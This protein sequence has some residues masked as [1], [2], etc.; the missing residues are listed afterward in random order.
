MSNI[1]LTQDDWNTLNQLAYKQPASSADT[2]AAWALLG[3]KGDS[4]GYVASQVKPRG[5]VLLFAFLQ[6]VILSPHVQTLKN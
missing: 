3:G 4:Y 1:T 6:C 5:Q 2:S